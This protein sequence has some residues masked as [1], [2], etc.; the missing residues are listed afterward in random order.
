M[1]DYVVYSTSNTPYQA[2]QCELLNESYR[3]SGQTGKLICL[4]SE[5]ENGSLP[6]MQSSIAEVVQ[7]PSYM[8]NADSGD[9]WGIA[10]KIESLRTWIADESIE[11]SILFL[12]PDMVFIEPIDV[13][14][15]PGQVIAQRWID[16]HV[17]HEMFK[18]YGDRCRD[19]LT[20]DSIFMYP[21]VMHS[22][23]V[24]AT[25]E[26]YCE[27][28]YQIR[29]EQ[30]KW[31]SDMY[32]LV[33]SAVEA[34]LDIQSRETLGVCNNWDVLNDKPASIVHYPNPFLDE[35]GNKI[36]FKQDFTANTLTKPWQG[37]PKPELATN[38]VENRMLRLLRSVVNQQ[39]L[40]SDAT[41]Y[42][43]WRRVQSSGDALGS[44]QAQSD[45]FVVF[46][47]YPGGF[48]NIR[49]SLELAAVAA[50]LLNRVLVLPPRT[51]FY[52]LEGE[53]GFED[54]FDLTDLGIETISFP[55]YCDEIGVVQSASLPDTWA[56]IR[57]TEDKVLT[58]DD[59]L[60]A[61]LLCLDDSQRFEAG[62][63]DYAAGRNSIALDPV[64]LQSH[65]IFFPK[66]LLGNFYLTIYLGDRLK[67]V[68]R[69]VAAHIHY[70]ESMFRT[71]YE[72]VDHLGD[73]N[74]AA[75]HIRRNDFQYKHLFIDGETILNNIAPLLIDGEVLY[76]ATDADD[77]AFL[78]PLKARYRV[79][80]YSDLAHLVDPGL[81]PNHIPCLEQLICTR[82]RTFIG[83]P[84][85]TLSS[86]I[87]RLRGYMCDVLDNNYYDNT[88]QNLLPL[89]SEQH[90]STP[91]W[92]VGWQSTWTREY[93]E[94]WSYTNDQIFV[95]VAAYR[96]PDVANTIRSLFERAKNPERVVVGVCLQE[97]PEAIKAFEFNNHPQV[98][99]LAIPYTEAEGAGPARAAI[100]TQLFNNEKYYLQ[101]D[102]HSRFAPDWDDYL[103]RAL[104]SCKS[105]KPLLSTYPNPFEQ[106]DDR[107]SYLDNMVSNGI[108]LQRIDAD[109]YLHVRG[110]F[111]VAGKAPIAGFWIGAGF[112]FTYGRWVSE[113]PYDANLYFKGEE[114]SL[115]IRSFTHGWDFFVPPQNMVFHDYNDNRIQSET[116]VRPLHW[117]DHPGTPSG[118]EL[119]PKLH[120]GEG[121]GS[122]RTIKEFEHQFGVNFQTGEIKQWA[123]EGRRVNF[124]DAGHRETC[125]EVDLKTDDI[126]PGVHEVWIFCL[127]NDQGDEVFRKDIVDPNVLSGAESSIPV[128]LIPELL[129]DNLVRALIWP[130]FAPG[131]FDQRYEY[132]I[133]VDRLANSITPMTRQMLVVERPDPSKD[134][135]FVVVAFLNDANEEIYREV[136]PEPFDRH[137]SFAF[138]QPA[139]ATGATI[140]KIMGVVRAGQISAPRYQSLSSEGS[141]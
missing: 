120:R 52:L 110:T 97:T 102:S 70:H 72:L 50:F 101:V 67:E 88:S 40:D 93:A 81:D 49:M 17:E 124:H 44:Y 19:A 63:E 4:C 113:V 92:L 115:T 83:N 24:R 100:Q 64:Q 119:L 31:E 89:F 80:F 66:N 8:R 71:G 45:K 84:L 131:E 34:G 105:A 25:I 65:S 10:N 118:Y 134:Y 6:P 69:Y 75:M 7:L 3:R 37:V 133:E 46:D 38:W 18:L 55:D 95:S 9:F 139:A 39:I 12:D 20:D 138:R 43:Y 61:N 91:S 130:M 104:D 47:Q 112:V 22:S 29:A 126:T 36:F 51:D 11:G 87:Y 86:Y 23:D 54:F 62:Y 121:V 94:V 32:G 136:F 114:D 2:W 128:Y 125:I 135:A 57:A 16:G 73:G 129:E 78:A 58:V 127:F 76:I 77:T 27:L 74:Y 33:L 60:V 21:Y 108:S 56:A 122:K 140:G 141:M 117:E 106:D 99:V 30:K 68:C 116:K 5:G 28:S 48:N 85:S 35:D 123:Q 111:N 103:R 26:R 42:L 96:D 90:P 13:D 107:D 15:V 82:A 59:D 98:R 79:V 1:P 109:G 137:D 132:E 41:D 14:V 53:C